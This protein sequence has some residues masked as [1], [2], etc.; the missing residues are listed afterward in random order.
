MFLIRE[1]TNGWQAV[2]MWWSVAEVMDM[3]S[4]HHN[5]ISREIAPCASVHIT[6]MVHATELGQNCCCM[7]EH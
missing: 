5:L 3:A 4:S 6:I 1:I 2:I 7:C